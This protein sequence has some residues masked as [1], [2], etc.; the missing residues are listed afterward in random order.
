MS[1][2]IPNLDDRTFQD[3]VTEMRALIPRYAPQWTDHN[4]TDP[5]IMFIELWAWL[6][7]I[8]LYRQN[9]IIERS[10][11]NFL[12][13]LLDPPEPVTVEIT[14]TIKLKNEIATLII[15][16]GTKFSTEPSPERTKIIF[17]TFQEYQFSLPIAE[18]DHLE[19]KLPPILARNYSIINDEILGMSDGSAHQ[20]FS[21]KNLPI[22]IDEFNTGSKVDGYNPNPRIKIKDDDA[23]YFVPDFLLSEQDYSNI[24]SNTIPPLKCFTIEKVTHKLRFGDGTYFVI[25]PKNAEIVCQ[26]Y[27]IVKGDEVRTGENTIK[28]LIISDPSIILDPPKIPFFKFNNATKV[29]L[30][31]DEDIKKIENESTKGGQYVFT[32]EDVWTN[33]LQSI[34]EPYRA[35]TASDYEYL[36]TQVFNQ[37]QISQLPQD[38]IRR[39]N[40]ISKRNLEISLFDIKE[41]EISIIIIPFPT[42][43]TD[44]T[45][46]PTPELIKK[47]HQFLDE[48]RL[49]AT[50]HHI[51]GPDYV[52]IPIEMTV[53]RKSNT[54][55]DALKITIEHEI[56]KLLNP[57]TGGV[58][59]KGWPFGRDIYPSELY[60]LLENLDGVDHVVSLSIKKQINQ[61][62]QL[63]KPIISIIVIS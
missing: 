26:S 9:I 50:R 37:Q 30:D 36:V 44:T 3:L 16:A 52:D 15:P 8:I 55:S 57:L 2:P 19:K 7:E 5:G 38:R 58:D 59:E 51:V 35:V 27:Q 61:I 33:G 60:Q 13:L 45:P 6:V 21:F 42:S 22:L 40:A 31:P 47:V 29:N 39:A 53:Y 28:K 20:L 49:L 14:L 34:W 1:L 24:K 41:G 25:P 54:N 12:K 62:N 48:R 11:I 63:P 17:E 46:G 56:K 23:W 43:E 18:S 4:I 32:L 10:K